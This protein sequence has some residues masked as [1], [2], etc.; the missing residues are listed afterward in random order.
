MLVLQYFSN[1]TENYWKFGGRC[2]AK[3]NAGFDLFDKFVDMDFERIKEML[4]LNMNTLTLLSYCFGKEMA[5]KGDGTIINVGSTASF[6]PLPHMSA[7]SASKAF[8]V[9]FSEALHKEMKPYGV[10]VLCVCP[11]TTKTAFLKEV[12]LE[13][14]NDK[15]LISKIAHMVAMKPEDVARIVWEAYQKNK[16]FSIPGKLNNIQY[17]LL[18]LKIPTESF[19]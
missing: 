15:R 5:K 6:Q 14:D 19:I 13:K 9:S 17:S 11:G 10:N 8:V 12:G 3:N 18:G 16:S 7:Y 1:E 2:I 4:Q